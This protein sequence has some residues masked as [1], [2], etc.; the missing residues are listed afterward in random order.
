MV[1][2]AEQPQNSLSETVNETDANY[3]PTYFGISMP[4]VTGIRENDDGTMTLTVE[5]VCDMVICNDAVITHELT[6]QFKDD[7]TFQYLRNEILD[8]GIQNIP[9][10]QYRIQ[11]K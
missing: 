3:T 8:D 2:I 10:Y 1:K 6:V 5:A 7:G 11:V 9:D 4:E